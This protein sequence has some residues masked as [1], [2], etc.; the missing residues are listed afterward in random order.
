[1]NLTFILSEFN[2]ENLIS[3]IEF[4][5]FKEYAMEQ[6]N[7][8]ENKNISESFPFYKEIPYSSIVD[9]FMGGKKA[10]YCHKLKKK[11]FIIFWM[12]FNPILIV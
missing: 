1:M 4:V 5:Q 2:I 7:V 12:K 10:L 6:L 11:C 9:E 3:V 8:K